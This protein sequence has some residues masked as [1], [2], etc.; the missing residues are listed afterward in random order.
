MMAAGWLS[1]IDKKKNQLKTAAE[2]KQN[3]DIFPRY[4]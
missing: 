4:V 1:S 3:P 2:E